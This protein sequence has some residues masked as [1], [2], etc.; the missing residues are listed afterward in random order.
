MADHGDREYRVTADELTGHPALGSTSKAPRLSYVILPPDVG[1]ESGGPWDI[2]V[3]LPDKEGEY[4]TDLEDLENAVGDLTLLLPPAVVHEDAEWVVWHS[5]VIASPQG[6]HVVATAARRP[7]APAFTDPWPA[8]PVRTV[9]MYRDESPP[10]EESGRTDSVPAF[11]AYTAM[12]HT[13]A[14]A[15]TALVVILDD[16]TRNEQTRVRLPL[17]PP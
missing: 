3:V 13:T 11:D 12:T 16:P 7:G 17:T 15:P 5:G 1:H 10:H 4:R 8:Q 9:F 14:S 2:Q 6:S